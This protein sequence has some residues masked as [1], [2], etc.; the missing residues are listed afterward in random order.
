MQDYQGWF[1]SVMELVEMDVDDALELIRAS[2]LPG[3]SV[4]HLAEGD[5][6]AEEALAYARLLLELG[7]PDMAEGLVHDVIAAECGT[8]RAVA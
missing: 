2:A 3:A 8:I 1:R 4:I 7:Q 5:L 6:D